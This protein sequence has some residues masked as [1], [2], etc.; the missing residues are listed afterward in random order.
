MKENKLTFQSQN[1]IVDYI[2][3]NIPGFMDPASMYKIASYFSEFFGFNSTLGKGNVAKPKEEIIFYDARNSH[4][5]CFKQLEYNPSSKS[6]W[7]GTKINFSGKNAAYCYNLIKAQRFD[8]SIF[9]LN[10]QT[11][12]LSRFD[13]CYYR[14]NDSTDTTE[15]FDK[16]LVDSRSQIQNSTNTRHITLKDSPE[17]KILKVNR[18]NN[19]L[20]YR[21]YEKDFGIRFELEIKH[22]QTKSVQDYLFHNQLDQF[23]HQLTSRYYKYS[24]RLFPLADSYSYTDWL[25]DFSRRY[26]QEKIPSSFLLSSYL[27]NTIDSQQEEERFF[28]LLQF[29]SF[30][31]SL[32]LNPTKDCQKHWIK[33]QL[34]YILK[35]PLAD[36]I[37]FTG[38]TI[39]KNYQRKKLLKYF[40]DLQKLDPIVKEF[41]DGAFRSYVSFPYVDSNNP[42]SNSWVIE[43][44]IVEEL[45]NFSYPFVFPK[46]FLCG[47]HKNDFRLK[48]L[49]IQSLSVK[50]QQKNLDIQEFFERVPVSNSRMVKMKEKLIQLLQELVEKKSLRPEIQILS[51]SGKKKHVQIKKLTSSSITR[52]IKYLKFNEI[53]HN[54]K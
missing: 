43:V 29:L 24:Q 5:F 20:H 52:R 44:F 53:I 21:V 50:D 9:A 38:I 32:N 12:S 27:Q 23:E 22:G 7:E 15:S 30:V 36:F 37:D 34:Y 11:L 18:R 6:F 19:A 10:R 47:E 16:F 13:L 33:N 49:L 14:T 54:H 48:L 8:W 51:K 35:F 28:H 45:F 2:S 39:T 31:K 4:K 26:S 17:G 40:K 3:F 41:S 1:L 46:S 42:F 25:V